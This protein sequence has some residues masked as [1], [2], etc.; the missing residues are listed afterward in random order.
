MNK[1]NLVDKCLKRKVIFIC[2]VVKEIRGY[3]V[4]WDKVG[5]ER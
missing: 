4:K 2:K 1:E 5:L 3:Y